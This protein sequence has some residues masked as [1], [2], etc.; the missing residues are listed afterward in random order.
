MAA[1]T[2]T[3]TIHRKTSR[4]AK[5][6][7]QDYH[8]PA[9]EQDL[10]LQVGAADAVGHAAPF[11]VASHVSVESPDRLKPVLQAK[12]ATLPSSSLAENVTVP[13]VGADGALEH[14]LTACTYIT[15]SHH[16][17]KTHEN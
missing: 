12:L 1:T 3:N 8:K 16:N 11:E 10:P 15:Q 13:S 5:P 17:E 6:Q 9:K 2:A 4:E 7:P 14:V